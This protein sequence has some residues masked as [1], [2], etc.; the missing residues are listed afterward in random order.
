MFQFMSVWLAQQEA[1]KEQAD[2]PTLEQIIILATILVSL[3]FV[4][5]YVVGIFRG[6]ALGK[7]QEASSHLDEFKRLREE[8]VLDE[9]EYKKV[10]TQIIQQQRE[11]IDF[12]ED[13]SDKAKDDDQS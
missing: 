10:K 4:A 3:L 11:K 1:I 2:P 9:V 6:S 7:T 13:T 12:S 8:G 5:F